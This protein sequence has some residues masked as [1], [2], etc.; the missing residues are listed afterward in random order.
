MFKTQQKAGGRDTGAAVKVCGFHPRFT[1][2]S[3]C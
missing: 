1:N 3:L 2:D